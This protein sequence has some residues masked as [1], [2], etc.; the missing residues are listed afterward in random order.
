MST[1]CLLTAEGATESLHAVR[2]KIS[3]IKVGIYLVII[4]I[5]MLKSSSHLGIS[6][7][8]SNMSSAEKTHRN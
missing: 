5:L 8:Y 1:I 4:E 3:M 7:W 6:R 2:P